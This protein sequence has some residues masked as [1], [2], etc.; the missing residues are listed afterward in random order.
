MAFCLESDEPTH[1][2]TISLCS[3]QCLGSHQLERAARHPSFVMQLPHSAGDNTMR[4]I[5]I[6]TQNENT[7]RQGLRSLKR[8]RQSP[9]AFCII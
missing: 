5:Q 2:S 8:H 1:T 4:R 3:G 9:L 6:P 7:I